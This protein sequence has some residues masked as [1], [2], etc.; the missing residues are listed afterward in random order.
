VLLSLAGLALALAGCGNQTAD[1]GIARAQPG[2][3]GPSASATPAE[4]LSEDERRLK[5]AE[6]MR[7]Q[8]VE[9]EDPG[10]DGGGGMRFRVGDKGKAGEL[11]KAIQACRAYAP[12]GGEPPK[13]DAEQLE[14]MR[15][16]AKC[17]RENGVPE[18][19]DP[20]ADGRVKIQR[21]VGE[22]ADEE[23]FEK[24]HEKC[25]QFQPKLGRGEQK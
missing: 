18:F 3:G 11:E 19:P 24:A 20:D 7:G 4:K 9:M 21:K 10:K 22:G 25:R 23:T 5:F 16:F 14:Q 8:G 6:C 12:N 15:K 17:M 1:D 2:A 13:L